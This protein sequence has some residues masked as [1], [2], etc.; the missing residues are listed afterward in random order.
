[1]RRSTSTYTSDERRDDRCHFCPNKCSRT[2]IDTKT[3]DGR[4]SRY[5]SG[6][7]LREGHGRDRRRRCKCSTPSARSA[8]RQLPEPGRL[9]GASS[10]SGTSTTPT[11]MP[12]RRRADRGRRGHD[13]AARRR[14]G[15]R[16]HA[17]DSQR[18]SADG[19]WRAGRRPHRHPARAQP[20]L[21]RRRSGGRTSRR[22]ASPSSNI[23]FSDATVRG[24]V[25]RGRQVRL[26]R[27]VL[28]VEG[29]P[30][31]HPQPAL[32]QAHD[33]EA[34]QL[35][36]LPVHHAHAD[37]RRRTRM[38]TTSCPIVAGAP[39]GHA[40]G[41]HQGG[42]LLRRAR[43]RV[44]RPGGDASPSRATARSRC[45]RRGAR[46]SA[47]PRTR[48]TSPAAR[49]CKALQPVRR[50]DAAPRAAR[51]SRSSRRENRVGVLAARPPVP[52][53]SRAST[54]ASPTSSRRSAIRSCRCA[55]F[56][57]DPKW[58]ARFFKDDLDRGFITTRSTSATSGRRTTRPTA[59]QKVWAAKFAARHPNVV[60]LDLSSFKCGHDAP[61]YGLIDSIINASGT[62]YSALHDIDA[63]K[64]GRLD[65]DPRQDLRAHAEALRGGARGRGRAEGRAAAPRRGE[66]ARAADA[67][68]QRAARAEARDRPI[69]APGGELDEIEAA[70]ARVPAP[71]STR[72]ADAGCCDADAVRLDVAPLPPVRQ[73]S[74]R[75]SD[76]RAPW[77]HDHE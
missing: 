11:P 69:A 37:V 23:V 53:R 30:G 47:S 63:N 67:D 74:W 59:S 76:Q 60:V 27:P 42:R 68:C 2:F 54:T 50:R 64:P 32:P 56:P 5:I 48:A 61:T 52:P 72:R 40:G 6:F 7:S 1:M 24:D 43:H 33:E 26:D 39:E 4:T 29:R 41:L 21:D 55:R 35:H 77:R 10:R 73:D 44:R 62:P 71:K 9:R 28:P 51:S 31:A 66:A 13:D 14:R 16:R 8:A 20:V 70:F 75:S 49:A 22:S 38:D 34:A 46:G 12:A 25:G 19:V 65:Q 57:K 15:R 36:L 58:L 45:S 17:A 18:S 3:P